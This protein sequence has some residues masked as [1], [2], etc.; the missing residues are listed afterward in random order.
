MRMR[1]LVAGVIGLVVAMTGVASAQ[2][3][4]QA[5]ITVTHRIDSLGI[6]NILA[7]GTVLVEDLGYG[8]TKGPVTVE[9]GAYEV[10]IVDAESG[11]TLFGP[12]DVTVES[13]NAYS[14]TATV[15]AGGPYLD[16]K[17]EPLADDGDGDGEG[18]LVFDH[19]ISGGPTVGVTVQ[20]FGAE[21]DAVELGT[22]DAGE[23]FEADLPVG[24]HELVITDETG[25]EVLGA[26]E[27][28]IEEGTSTTVRASS[29]LG[30]GEAE[31]STAEPIRTPTR[32]D[33]GA[34]GIEGGRTAVVVLL[35]GLAAGAAALGTSRRRAA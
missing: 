3:D 19:D 21:E 6:V 20:P 15:G 34:G 13:G 11:S 10:E 1:L 25:D 9:P 5:T 22:V 35:A 2:E 16:V 27:F 8:E 26:T 29:V 4:T 23:S 31:T 7:G 30:D 17:A 18:T 14:V 24:E 12:V 33:T 28:E 32:V